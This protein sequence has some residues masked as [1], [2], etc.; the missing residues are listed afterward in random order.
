MRKD[1]QHWLQALSLAHQLDPSQVPALACSY[2]QVS[3]H[4]QQLLA[5]TALGGRPVSFLLLCSLYVSAETC[6]I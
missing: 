5:Y 3:P 2:A 6:L 4:M 1:L